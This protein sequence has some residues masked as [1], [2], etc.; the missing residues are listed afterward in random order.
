[1]MIQTQEALSP[2][3]VMK[4]DSLLDLPSILLPEGY[5]IRSFI[6]GDE[7]AWETIICEAFHLRLEFQ[8]SMVRRSTLLLNASFLFVMM[9][10][11]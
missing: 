10:N 4:R 1:M 7:T 6:P 8:K 2:Q 11:R 3:L 9:D 5:G